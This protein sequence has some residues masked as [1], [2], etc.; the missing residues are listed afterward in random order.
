MTY[1]H[2]T[3]ALRVMCTAESLPR[4][5]KAFWNKSLDASNAPEGDEEGLELFSE[6]A[7]QLGEKG[8]AKNQ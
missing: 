3:P 8:P 1:I 2:E 5:A 7:R 4:H 6:A